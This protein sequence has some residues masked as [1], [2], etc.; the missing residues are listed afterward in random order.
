[1]SVSPVSFSLTTEARRPVSYVLHGPNGLLVE[2]RVAA[3]RAELDPQGFNTSFLDLQATSVQEVAATCQAAPFFGG[4]RLVILRNP[5]SPRR[6]A[7]ADED[8]DDAPDGK[9]AWAD[10][11]EVL[12]RAPRENSFIIRQDGT[13]ASNHGAHKLAKEQG[14]KIETYRIP[15]GGEL[16]HWT[17]DRARAIGVTLTH[18]AQ[19]RLL[20][21][22]FPNVWRAESRFDTGA[23]DPRLI[24][25]ELA[26]LAAAADDGALVDVPL[27]EAL[28]PD[29]AGYVAFALN[30]AIFGGNTRG[31]L[32]ELE[33]VLAT[34]EPA[35]RLLGQLASEASLHL[36][37]S[38]GDGFPNDQIANVGGMTEGRVKMARQKG[39]RASAPALAAVTEALR[40]ADAS[41]KAGRAGDIR[42]EIVPLVADMAEALRGPSGMRRG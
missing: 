7:T 21:L 37:L 41:V 32:V 14:W 10:V 13:L 6:A 4:G 20:D 26:K 31:A 29:R 15:R 34:G 12:R 24:T 23:P 1:M 19:E 30:T 16:L 28:V 17:D 3:L 9:L 42:E 39:P 27:V 5:V 18:D 8:T 35:E 40:A 33:K 2:E 36:A 11:A 22:L 38:V 25:A